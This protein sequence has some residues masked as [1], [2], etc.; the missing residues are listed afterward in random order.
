M[1]TLDPVKLG[2]F[3]DDPS[4]DDANIAFARINAN[5]KLLNEEVRPIATGGT[6]NTAGLA[7]SATKLATVRTLSWTGDVTGSTTFDGTANKSTAMTLAAS[8][9][10]AGTF[11]SV[12]VN[13][14]GLVTAG[15]DVVTGLVTSTTAAGIAN[16]VTTNTDTFLNVTEKVG[17]AAATVKASAQLAGAGAV[18][19]T[20]DATGKVT[21]TSP[22]NAA[23]ASKLLNPV[24]INGTDF[25]GTQ[26]IN[27]A[28]MPMGVPI[29]HGGLRSTIETGYV[30]YDGQ[31][32]N[33]AD[34]PAMWEVIQR[35]FPPISDN[36]WLSSKAVR[37]FYSSGDGSTTFRMPDLNG[38]QEGS[39]EGVFLRGDGGGTIGE[40]S[41]VPGNVLNDAIRNITGTLGYVRPNSNLAT[42]VW[43]GALSWG[44]VGEGISSFGSGNANVYD[45][46]LD[47]S[48]AVP[49]A[50]E[51]RPV[52]AVGVW[53][54]R[55]G[56]T[57]TEVANPTLHAVLTGGNTFNGGQAVVG[58]LAVSGNFTVNGVGLF[59]LGQTW[60]AVSGKSLGVT[61]TNTTG[62]PIMVSATVISGPQVT[63]LYGS[64]SGDFITKTAFISGAWGN[65]LIFVPNLAT[66]LIGSESSASLQ[67]WKETQL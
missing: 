54:C 63:V 64:V 6:G 21:I 55:V 47:A 31:L 39:Y 51:N 57:L 42:T 50:A 62:R 9:V 33:R 28:S 4:A 26:D 23:T 10:T 14:K 32:L 59:G 12:T 16:V 53:I 46:A 36:Q 60:K 56:N 40:L 65:V 17:T 1:A 49:T 35:K 2:S 22:T 66:Y 25:D 30:A 27:I 38:V 15:T 43:Q 8:G 29:F 48:R 61:Y 19:V 67:L 5:E 52:S 45:I 24:K 44:G 13:A 7:A 41:V 37:A 20:S 11:K 34:Y 3:V 58:D 18:T